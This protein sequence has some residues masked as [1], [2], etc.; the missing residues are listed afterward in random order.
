VQSPLRQ[1]L[2]NGLQYVASKAA[3]VGPT[4]APAF[5]VGQF[6]ITV[7]SISPGL[8]Q[9]ETVQEYDF[10]QTSEALAKNSA[11]PRLELRPRRFVSSLSS[12]FGGAHPIEALGKAAFGFKVGSQPR[13]LAIKQSTG[14]SQQGQGGVGRKFGVKLSGR[15]GPCGL[16]GRFRILPTS[17]SLSTGSTT[18]AH[19]NHPGRHVIGA[20][21]APVDQSLP[22]PIFPLP[23]CQPPL[24]QKIFIVELQFFQAGAGT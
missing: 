24:T 7:N 11:I 2:G 21:T 4:R 16:R 12:P 23:L 17:S 20:L 22:Q 13:N 6:G 9:S 15:R 8:T 5:E 14:H 3:V 10:K 18:P 19:L 1:G